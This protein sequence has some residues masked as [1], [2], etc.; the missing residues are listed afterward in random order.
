MDV[1]ISGWDA[2]GSPERNAVES[3]GLYRVKQS[4]IEVRR[5]AKKGKLVWERLP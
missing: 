4:E 3:K 2:D 5:A 1:Y